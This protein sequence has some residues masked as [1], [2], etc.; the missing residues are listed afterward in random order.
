MN[1]NIPKILALDP[2]TKYLAVAAFEGEYLLDW[3]IKSFR[4]KYDGKKQKKILKAV[5]YLVDEYEADILALNKKRHY[6]D[7]LNALI[8]EIEQYSKRKGLKLFQYSLKEIED[9]FISD[10]KKNTTR[11]SEV[12]VARYP[13]LENIFNREQSNQNQYYM[14]IFEAVALG[15]ICF[16][17]FKKS[18]L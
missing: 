1:N 9:F 14:R 11:L 5:D 13:E 4:G 15:V 17:T 6:S 16:S 2:G 8:Q 10:G 18:D 3:T 12:I 7:N